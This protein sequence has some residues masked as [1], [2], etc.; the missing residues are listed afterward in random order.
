VE[1]AARLRAS[2][3]RLELRSEPPLTLRATPGAVY[4]VSS[5]AGPVGGDRLRLD[6]EVT[7]GATLTVRSAAAAVHHPGPTGLPSHLDLAVKVGAHSTL[8]WCPEPAVFV[9]GCDHRMTIRIDLADTATL[10]WRDEQVLGR[11]GEAGGSV[12]T[13]LQVDRSGTPL[14]RADTALGPRWPDAEGPAGTA[15]ARASGTVLVVGPDR[16]ATTDPSVPTTLAPGQVPAARAARL[17][18]GPGA[19][20]VVALAERADLLVRALDALVVEPP[21]RPADT[22]RPCALPSDQIDPAEVTP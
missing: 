1:A 6:L 14:L 19:A 4:L 7:E 12:R 10:V 2:G 17:D 9:A 13:R 15:G 5:A 21:R 11:H 22:P 3:D 16:D 8:R 18:L 20:M